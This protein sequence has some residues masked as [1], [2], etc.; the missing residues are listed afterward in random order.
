MSRS[1]PIYS[2]I[3]SYEAR[4]HKLASSTVSQA[5]GNHLPRERAVFEKD[6][7][8]RGARRC[9]AA[10][11]GKLP[12]QAAAADRAVAPRVAETP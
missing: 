9:K 10:R 5:E 1:R 2:V 3:G 11:S 7:S 6:L 4:Q 8:P 12:D